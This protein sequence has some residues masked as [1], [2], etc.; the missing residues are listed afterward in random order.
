[1][2]R[3]IH[4]RRRNRPGKLAGMADL[5]RVISLIRRHLEQ[6]KERRVRGGI[7]GLLIDG[8]ACVG[9]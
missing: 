3:G 9:G 2:R 1:M 4:H 7:P 8:L 6:E 5:R